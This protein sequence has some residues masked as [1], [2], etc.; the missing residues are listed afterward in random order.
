MAH[1]LLF[2]CLLPALVVQA[3][4]PIQLFQRDAG[5][6]PAACFFLSEAVNSCAYEVTDSSP[7]SQAAATTAAYADQPRA[8]GHITAAAAT[9]GT[10]YP[11]CM[12]AENIIESCMEAT[13]ILTYGNNAPLASCACYSSEIWQPSIFDNLMLSCANYLKTAGPSVYPY[14]SGFVG[15]CANYGGGSNSQTAATS[16]PG[17]TSLSKNSQTS[18]TSTPGITSPSKT[19]IV[20]QPPNTSSISQTTASVKPSAG[21]SLR[22]GGFAETLLAFAAVA[23]SMILLF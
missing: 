22:G 3:N 15:F 17:I 20:T 18:A 1:I 2:L 5:D 19:T 14:A 8:I 10:Y 21:S 7:A 16:T 11:P 9:T 6:P 4:M 12:T 13:P 23:L